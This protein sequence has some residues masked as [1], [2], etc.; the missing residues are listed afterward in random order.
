MQSC[1]G[2]QAVM[3]AL[4]A[5]VLAGKGLNAFSVLLKSN[6][7]NSFFLKPYMALL[8]AVNSFIS[9]LLNRFT[10]IE[11]HHLQINSIIYITILLGEVLVCSAPTT[12]HI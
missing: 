8:Y 3:S 1:N 7:E 2:R 12:F 4:E 10:L 9:W 6:F 11:Y 5:L